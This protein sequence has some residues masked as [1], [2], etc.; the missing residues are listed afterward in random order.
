M[1]LSGRDFAPGKTVVEAIDQAINEEIGFQEIVSGLPMCYV[2]HMVDGL[3][4]LEGEEEFLTDEVGE[5]DSVDGVFVK[6]HYLKWVH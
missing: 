6:R 2:L 5:C 4:D 3:P 1:E